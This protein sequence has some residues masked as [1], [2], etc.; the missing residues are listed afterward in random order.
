MH[1]NVA[2]HLEGIFARGDR[3]CAD[4]LERAFRLGCRFDGWDEV[5]RMDLWE[6]AMAE[7]R[8][9]HG[10]DPERYLGAIAEDA[11]LPWAHIDV[12]V[13]Q[14]FLRQ[15]M[16]KAIRHQA[17]PPCGKP[18]G[19]LLHPSN[20]ADAEAAGERKL[21]CY[22]CG[23]ACDLDGMKRERLFFLRR[24]N[25]WS[26]RAPLGGRRRTAKTDRD[27]PRSAP[28]P[29]TDSGQ[30]E[31]AR[32]R[33]RYSKLGPAA[34]LS[35]L[36]LVRHLPR[37]FRRAG[38]EIF[39]SRGF[40]PKPGLSFGPALGLG[41]PSL[42]ELMDVDLEHTVPGVRTWDVIDDSTRTEL[43]ADEVRDRLAAVC[44]PGI[45][46]ESCTI[47]R[48]NGHPLV[49]HAGM[50]PDLGLGKL[51]DAVDIVIRPAADGITHDAARLARLAASL[52]AKPE[53]KVA[54]GDKTI[55]VRSHVLDVTVIDGA[56]ATR[57]AAALDWADGALL[58]A[59]V[60]ATAAGSAKPSE[61]ARALGVWGSEDL[62]GEHAL[63]A[64]LGVV[65]LGTPALGHAVERAAPTHDAV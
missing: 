46:I 15:E 45:E 16:R 49:T 29:N 28:R 65:E 32:Y 6:R 21:V 13:D 26:P 12:G 63:L 56:A 38:M 53:A 7:E 36:D 31:P 5:L 34:F 47:V 18:A 43:A 42:G 44:P 51:I 58:R 33:L 61:V 37:A 20:V 4:L 22:D 64:R 55:D 54:R 1:A 40:H 11:R 39:Y 9:A 24:M 3:A 50:K 57:L 62:R 17:A 52:M 8:T 14:E 35:H 23:V 30:G 41:I 19:Q 59:R 27:A 48:L 60:R 2:S 25:A 10:F